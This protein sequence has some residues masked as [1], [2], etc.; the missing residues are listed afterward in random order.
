MEEPQPATDLPR[1]NITPRA[2]SHEGPS[3][4]VTQLQSDR[5]RPQARAVK[6]AAIAADLARDQGV[7]VRQVA[8]YEVDARVP[9]RETRR[10]IEC[11]VISQVGVRRLKQVVAE[12]A[13]IGG[14]EANRRLVT[15]DFEVV[16]QTDAAVEFRRARQPVAG[17]DKTQ[18]W[19]VLDDP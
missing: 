4:V 2:S 12:A 10:G 18:F 7:L 6:L 15:R 9:D 1:R 11:Q 5:A 13:D 14:I 3:K 8:E 16:L 19:S 17:G